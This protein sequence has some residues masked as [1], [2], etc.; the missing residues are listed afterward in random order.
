M[1]TSGH[2]PLKEIID[3]ITIDFDEAFDIGAVVKE[4]NGLGGYI[5][6]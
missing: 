2:F 1:T 4:P 6:G 5:F 3:S